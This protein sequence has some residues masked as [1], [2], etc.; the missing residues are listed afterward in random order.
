MSGMAAERR[1]CGLLLEYVLQT[2]VAA[3]LAL[4]R[5]RQGI[6]PRIPFRANVEYRQRLSTRGQPE[7]RW[8]GD[9]M[10]YRSV[11]RSQQ[12]GLRPV[13]ST[14]PPTSAAIMAHGGPSL[15][16]RLAC[17]WF[18]INAWRASMPKSTST[19]SSSPAAAL[20]PCPAQAVSA[21]AS[22]LSRHMTH[23]KKC[24]KVGRVASRLHQV[25]QQIRHSI[26]EKVMKDSRW[27]LLHAVKGDCFGLEAVPE[28]KVKALVP[29]QLKL[30][31]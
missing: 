27:K 15:S 3:Q 29:G 6:L 18:V 28:A 20:A 25:S 9:W 7:G 26:G 8:G 30:R 21:V 4:Q 17:A 11:T 19:K 13:V 1:T 16:R 14:A 10:T 24:R 23:L 12:Q 22:W 5:N 31:L 2:A